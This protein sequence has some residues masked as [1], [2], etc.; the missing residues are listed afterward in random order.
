MLSAS[1]QPTSPTPHHTASGEGWSIHVNCRQNLYTPEMPCFPFLFL[2]GTVSVPI[3]LA[4]LRVSI[5][6]VGAIR[7]SLHSTDMCWQEA[8]IDQQKLEANHNQNLSKSEATET[9][10]DPGLILQN[11][12]N[13]NHYESIMS[14]GTTRHAVFHCSLST[15]LSN[16][17]FTVVAWGVTEKNTDPWG[18]T[19]LIKE[20]HV[21]PLEKK[22]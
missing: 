8:Y 20:I 19:N 1:P 22:V 21:F 12:N 13:Q 17:H 18:A 15:C 10:K 3:P 14:R 16:Q 4:E 6:D 11:Q 7:N 5:T 9:W 2:I